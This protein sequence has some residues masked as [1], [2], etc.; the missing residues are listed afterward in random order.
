MRPFE[1]DCRVPT[2]NFQDPG[3]GNEASDDHDL[4]SIEREMMEQNNEDF[5]EQRYENAIKMKDLLQQ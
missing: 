2:L 3:D 1:T 5:D 4:C